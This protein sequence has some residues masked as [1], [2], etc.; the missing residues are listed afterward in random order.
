MSND[1]SND[2]NP[3]NG[4]HMGSS[5]CVAPFEQNDEEKKTPG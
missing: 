4:C 1:V 2:P 3:L 5:T